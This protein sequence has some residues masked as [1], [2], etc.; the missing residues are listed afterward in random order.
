MSSIQLKGV[1][2][3]L[4][5]SRLKILRHRLA[6]ANVLEDIRKGNIQKLKVIPF[7]AV[8]ALQKIS[9]GNIKDFVEVHV[10]SHVCTN[11]STL[12][13]DYPYRIKY[14]IY[15]DG[16]SIALYSECIDLEILLTIVFGDLI[17]YIEF[18]E[19]SRDDV[20]FKYSTMSREF[21]TQDVYEVLGSN[22]GCAGVKINS[23]YLQD[24]ISELVS[25]KEEVS[26]LIIASPCVDSRTI[27][28]VMQLAKELLKNPLARLFVITSSPIIQDARICK[29][30]YKELFTNYV[31]MIEVAKEFDRLYLCNSEVGN[32]EIIANR[33]TYL[34]SYDEK[35]APRSEL[36]S[37]KSYSYIDS[38]TL[39]YLRDCLCT[40]HIVKNKRYRYALT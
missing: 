2:S 39:K 34:T 27:E 1:S 5:E 8:S 40:S 26:E 21:L 25:S 24:V 28:V 10:E 30:S 15:V 22:V 36:L 7:E 16:E 37:V 9:Q 6:L 19:G 32:V 20:M 12:C 17:K 31:E 29:M 35:L 33:Y 18:L 14:S 38:F 13:R 3:L 11:L 23:R 4:K